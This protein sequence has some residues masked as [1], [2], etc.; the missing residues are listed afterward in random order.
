MQLRNLVFVLGVLI[1]AGLFGQT[2]TAKQVIQRGALGK[3][4]QVFDETEQWTTPLL[5]AADRD[6]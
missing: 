2:Q 1:S 6:V 4:A 5:V 3:P